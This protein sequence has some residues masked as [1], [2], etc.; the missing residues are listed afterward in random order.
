MKNSS[1][2]ILLLST[3]LMS[4]GTIFAA[5]NV[6]MQNPSLG[7]SSRRVAVHAPAPEPS[8]QPTLAGEPRLTDATLA[9]RREMEERVLRDRELA[10][11]GS[12]Q[13]R[14]TSRAY[15]ESRVAAST[16]PQAPRSAG[17]RNTAGLEVSL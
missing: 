11:L 12:N 8:K 4:A 2:S 17:A 15:T 13:S 14:L 9:R 3:C 10:R 7:N 6:S 16:N 5:E 1:Y